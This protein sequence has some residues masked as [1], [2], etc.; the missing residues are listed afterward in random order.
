MRLFLVVFKHCARVSILNT[1]FQ[2]LTYI[3]PVLL[4]SILLNLP[5]W[6][7]LELKDMVFS[8]KGGLT[9]VTENVTTEVITIVAGTW[10]RYN[11]Y[12]I[13]YYMHWTLFLTTG[14]LP[15]AALFYLNLRIYF[16]LKSVR[17]VR[18]STTK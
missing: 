17:Q 7:E 13:T 10:L 12:Y 9:P 14:V 18:T 1:S 5:K 15:L 6:F 2:A 16:R 8:E 11:D 3:L 4:W